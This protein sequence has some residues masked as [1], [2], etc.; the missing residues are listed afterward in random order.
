MV[1]EARSSDGTTIRYLDTEATYDLWAQHYDTDGN[2]LTA[3][4][5]EEM[6]SLLP[7]LL[8]MLEFP[9][10][11]K[12]VDLGCGT[13]RNTVHLVSLTKVNVVAL[14]L[15]QKMLN[16]ARS[17][18]EG[19]NLEGSIV[20]EV[21]DLL[22]APSPPTTALGATAIIS[23]LV[24]EHIPLQEYF[25]AVSKMLRPGG[26]LLLTN[27]HSD[28]GKI[29]QAGFVDPQTGKRIRPTSYAHSIED[30]VSECEVRGFELLS[31]F[32]ERTLTETDLQRLGP[33]A[34]KAP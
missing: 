22:K 11:W 24:V 27:M 14:D 1:G 6:E 4:D 9:K 17:K 15:S 16:I 18:T 10:P 34:A 26:L 29:T 30:I 20:F 12:I 21:Y 2:F 31:S 19:A 7:K 5:S 13:G 25:D 32:R 33:R 8:S 28:M 23:T 3:V